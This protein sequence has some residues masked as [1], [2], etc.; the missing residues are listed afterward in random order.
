VLIRTV[1]EKDLAR[2]DTGPHGRKK[3]GA[4]RFELW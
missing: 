1:L 2:C 4:T 3:A